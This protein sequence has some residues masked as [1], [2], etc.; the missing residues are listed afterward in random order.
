V[1]PIEW[2]RDTFVSMV[3]RW[4]PGRAD[5]EDDEWP[6]AER[7]IGTLLTTA[8]PLLRAV[9][10]NELH[11]VSAPEIEEFCSLMALTP[12]QGQW[13]V[14]RIRA[15]AKTSSEVFHTIDTCLPDARSI[16]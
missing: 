13:L 16:T 5:V 2:P 3:R 7:M 1:Q 11:T 15:R 4:L 9:R 14:G 8:K 10:L 6:Q 12:R